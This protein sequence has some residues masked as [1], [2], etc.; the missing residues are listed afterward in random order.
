[1]IFHKKEKTFKR[2]DGMVVKDERGNADKYLVSIPQWLI[3]GIFPVIITLCAWIWTASS[4]ASK[5][6]AQEAL[7]LKF[8]KVSE[9]VSKHDAI[10]PKM[11]DDLSEVKSDLKYLIR[12]V[13][14]TP[15]P[16]RDI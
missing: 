16:R 5:V 2:R 7:N 10:F 12:A 15:Q 11:Q 4:Y 13:N 14:G 3:A 6:Q 8:E 9:I 1:M